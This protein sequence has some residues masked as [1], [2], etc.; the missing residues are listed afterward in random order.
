MLNFRD[1]KSEGKVV[2]LLHFLPE[3]LISSQNLVVSD[4]C[5]VHLLKLTYPHLE[6]MGKSLA[7]KCLEG[8]GIC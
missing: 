2:F 1:G 5:L 3:L 4:G 7:Q 6:K 8:M